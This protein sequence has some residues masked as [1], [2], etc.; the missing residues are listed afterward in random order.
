MVLTCIPSSYCLCKQTPVCYVEIIFSHDKNDTFWD[1]E[2]NTK[3]TLRN[4][5]AL[6]ISLIPKGAHFYQYI[7]IWALNAAPR[8]HLISFCHSVHQ[9]RVRVQNE[10]NSKPSLA[11][12]RLKKDQLQLCP[13]A[14]GLSIWIWYTGHQFFILFPT[15]KIKICYCYAFQG[16][17][18]FT[19]CLN[20]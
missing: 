19:W 9:L 5:L 18:D 8:T 6:L 10:L 4:H 14:N 20:Y 13:F 2:H 15:L 11:A 17:V 1:L 12:V 7:Y 16:Y 3:A